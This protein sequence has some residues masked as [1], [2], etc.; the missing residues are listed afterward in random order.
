MTDSFD[1]TFNKLEKEVKGVFTTDA[2]DWRCIIYGLN[3]IGTCKTKGC[4]AEGRTDV[5]HKVGLGD[6]NIA[7]CVHKAICP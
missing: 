4:D 7:Q 2:P 6:F 3:M 1:F 5:H